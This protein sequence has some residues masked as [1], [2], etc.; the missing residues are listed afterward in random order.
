[1]EFFF[2]QFLAD[3]KPMRSLLQFS[4]K[5]SAYQYRKP[6]SISARFLKQDGT[7]L[8]WGSGNGHFSTFLLY[9]KQKT[10][11]YGFGENAAPSVIADNPLFEF[12]AA[13]ISEPVKLPFAESSFDLVV[14]MGVLEHVHDS[15]GEQLSSLKEINRIL[16]DGGFFLCFHLPYCGSWVEMLIG[17][18]MPFIKIGYAHT[19]RFSKNDVLR[20]C[21]DSKFNFYE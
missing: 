19:K 15:G 18:F 14:S 21:S 9:N 12:V 16:K 3:C 20:L 10:T 1:M 4:N 6:F 8:D 7:V 11:A 17:A 2:E 13:N 5:T